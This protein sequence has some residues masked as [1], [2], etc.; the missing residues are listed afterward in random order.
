MLVDGSGLLGSARP[1][2]G[3]LV[4]TL[5]AVVAVIVV[6]AAAIVDDEAG[7]SAISAD[8]DIDGRSGA[9]GERA[10]VLARPS[11]SSPPSSGASAGAAAASSS[12][13][14]E[15]SFDGASLGAVMRYDDPLAE[16]GVHDATAPLADEPEPAAPT[17]VPPTTAPTTPPTTEETPADADSTTT[18]AEV[19]TTGDTS[20]E[21]TTSTE[22]RDGPLDGDQPDDRDDRTTRHDARPRGLRRCRP[23][24]DGAQHPALDPM[25]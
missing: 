18:T 12:S 10:M 25:V 23:W 19:A 3:A 22:G 2:R 6:I 7:P 11:P 16:L 14:E 9:D 21:D 15:S 8:A 4:A 17:T 13:D 5:F 1:T 20:A 24:R